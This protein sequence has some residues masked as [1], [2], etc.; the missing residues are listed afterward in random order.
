MP[1]YDYQCN[2]CGHEFELFQSMSDKVRR[3]CPECGEPRLKR[4]IGTGGAV[5]FRGSGFYETDY[6]SDSYRKGAEADKK[7]TEDKKK[8]KT[9]D[10]KSTPKSSKKKTP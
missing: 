2:H 8:A 4:L 3:K 5:L 9:D 1:T 6:R 7:K 10:K